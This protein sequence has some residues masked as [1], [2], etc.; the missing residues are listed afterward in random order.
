MSATGIP[1]TPED[2]VFERNGRSA[3]IRF[4]GTPYLIFRDGKS[5]CCE[6]VPVDQFKRFEALEKVWEAERSRRIAR[7]LEGKF[8]KEDEGLNVQGVDLR[9]RRPGPDR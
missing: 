2:G 6:R 7:A 9:P 1:E 5:W 8:P 3:A 4:R